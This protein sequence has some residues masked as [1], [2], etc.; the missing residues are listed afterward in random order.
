MINQFEPGYKSN[1]SGF[2]IVVLE[3]RLWLGGYWCISRIGIKLRLD[4]FLILKLLILK[5]PLIQHLPNAPQYTK[6]FHEQSKPTHKLPSP[7]S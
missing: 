1:A 2:T 7:T 3:L 5:D 6:W 4:G